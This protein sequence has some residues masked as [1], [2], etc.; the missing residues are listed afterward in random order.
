MLVGITCK[1]YMH[2]GRGGLACFIEYDDTRL[3]KNLGSIT[4]VFCKCGWFCRG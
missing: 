3:T 1:D 2:I 4:Y